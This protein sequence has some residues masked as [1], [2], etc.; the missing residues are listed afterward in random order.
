MPLE[1]LVD[2]APGVLL[3][4]E[5]GHLHDR[6]VAGG[7]EVVEFRFEHSSEGVVVDAP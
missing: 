2:D 6:A 5:L 7:S 3:E 1:A 4:V